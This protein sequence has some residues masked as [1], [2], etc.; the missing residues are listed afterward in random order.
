M[1]R[2]VLLA[3]VLPAALSCVSVGN[4]GLVTRSSA[5]P[6][7][8]LRE[9]QPY[10]ELGPVMGQSCRFSVL[11]ALPGGHADLESAMEKALVG[12]DADAIVNV[13]VSNSLYVLIPIYSL[14]A[15]TCT[16]LKGIAIVYESG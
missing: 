7:R 16:T 2:V 11:A 3:L 12:T 5:D 9:N 8:P 15:F 14:A 13:T 1:Y 10:S 4:L 6:G